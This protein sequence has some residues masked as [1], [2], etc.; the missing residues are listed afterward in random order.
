MKIVGTTPMGN[1]PSENWVDYLRMEV[2]V[3]FEAPRLDFD[4]RVPEF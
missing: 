2:E 3:D 4:P 1:A